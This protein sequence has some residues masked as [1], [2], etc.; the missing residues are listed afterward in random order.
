MPNHDMTLLWH[1]VEKW[2]A[3]KP[4]DEAL[5]FG[6]ERLTWRQFKEAMDRTAKAFLAAGVQP[7][8]RIGMV[9]MARNEFIIS[10]M[11]ASKIGAVWLG[12]SP[13]FSVDE[14][15]YMVLHSEPA[16][17]ITLREYQGI[18]LTSAGMTFSIECPSITDVLVIGDCIEGTKCYSEYT[19]AERSELDEALAARAAEVSQDD[20]VLLMYTS[21]STGKPK[22]V[23]QTQRAIVENIRQEIH[24]MGFESTGRVLLH[25]P[26]NH[27]AAD[28]EIGF[29]AIMSGAALIL[30][31]RFDPQ[32]SLEMIERERV[33]LL[34]QVPVMYLMQFQTPKFREMD[35]SSVRTFVWGGSGAPRVMLDTLMGIASRTGARLVT[36]YGSTEL[37]GFATYTAPDDSVEVLAKGVGRVVPPFEVKVVDGERNTLGP[38]ETGELAFRGPN[39]MKG[40]F[41]NNA[42]TASVIDEDG[43]YYTSDLGYMAEDGNIY[44]Q[45]RSSEMFKSGGENVFPR[46]VEDV[47]EACEGVMFSAVIGVPDDLYAEVGYAFVMTKPGHVVTDEALRAHAREHLANFKVPKKFDIRPMLPLL[48]NGKVNKMALKKELGLA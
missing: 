46:E 25:F 6:D 16:V 48:A 34:G 12:M 21:G 7:G 40:Y 5:V 28:V 29:G 31:D 2:A 33:T 44:L 15:R 3:E 4:D 30:M 42:V 18:D 1:Y 43:W 38:N 19:G 13:K 47:L 22:G 24:Y 26:I 20:E 45:G 41:K 14:L 39:V 35:W 32:E 10:F 37:C 11:A 23:L 9:S 27:V 17:L 36:G 8:D